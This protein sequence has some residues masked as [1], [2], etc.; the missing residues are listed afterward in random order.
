VVDVLALRQIWPKLTWMQRAALLA[1]ARHDDYDKAAAELGIGYP[2][3]L[4]HLHSARRQ[5]LRWWHEH[6]APSRP[7][8]S[9]LRKR[10][11]AAGPNYHTVTGTVRR[12]RGGGSAACAGG[13][14]PARPAP[15]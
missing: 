2:T 9:D 10:D 7:W 4:S 1:L 5:F 14:D 15:V 13:P 8:R 11:P 3:L 12:R 6:E